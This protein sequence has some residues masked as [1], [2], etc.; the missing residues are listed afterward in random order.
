MGVSFRSRDSTWAFIMGEVVSEAQKCHEMLVGFRTVAVL[1]WGT[2]L[3][4]QGVKREASPTKALSFSTR[5]GQR[6]DAMRSGIRHRLGVGRICER[7]RQHGAGS[8]TR[9]ALH[10]YRRSAT[11]GTSEPPR[12]PS[13]GCVLATNAA[14]VNR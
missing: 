3:Y 13:L 9:Q 5:V 2:V 6:T 14:V 1:A 12:A 11:P 10:P 4:L 8:P 7:H